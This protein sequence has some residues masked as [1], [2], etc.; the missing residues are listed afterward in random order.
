MIKLIRR[1]KNIFNS[2]PGV[3]LYLSGL[4]STVLSVLHSAVIDAPKYKSSSLF[5]KKQRY[6]SS[7]R[8]SFVL[9]TAK[10]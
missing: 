5:R 2:L 9:A 7:F 4:C 3:T 8:D 1:F 10:K 6:F